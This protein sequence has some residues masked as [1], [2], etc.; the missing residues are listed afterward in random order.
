MYLVHTWIGTIAHPVCGTTNGFAGAIFLPS[1]TEF[2]RTGDTG[3][4]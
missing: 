4:I 2:A 1:L 3:T